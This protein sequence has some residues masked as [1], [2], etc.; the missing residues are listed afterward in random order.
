MNDTHPPAWRQ[1]FPIDW[2]QDHYV[3]RRDFTKFLVLTAFR[4]PW[5]SWASALSTGFVATAADG[6]SGLLLRL[7]IFL[8]AECCP[9]LIPTTTIRVCCCVSTTRPCRH[10]ARN[11]RIWAVP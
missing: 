1:D 5:C 9:S 3:A 7:L 8:S 10:S 6:P 4:S 2:P 11:A